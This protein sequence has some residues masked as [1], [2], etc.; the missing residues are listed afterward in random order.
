MVQRH[1][2]VQDMM[3]ELGEGI[4]QASDSVLHDERLTR[5]MRL[6]DFEAD[7]TSRDTPEDTTYS[8]PNGYLETIALNEAPSDNQNVMEMW[9]EELNLTDD[10]LYGLFAPE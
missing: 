9:G 2:V 8:Q 7:K 4:P 3:H 1:S 6:R 10:M 5:L